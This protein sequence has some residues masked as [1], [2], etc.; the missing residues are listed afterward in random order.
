VIFKKIMIGIF[1]CITLHGCNSKDNSLQ[2]CKELS[3]YVNSQLPELNK[4]IATIYGT[5]NVSIT[6]SYCDYNSYNDSRFNYTY[7]VLEESSNSI[8]NLRNNF[9]SN[10]QVQNLFDYVK[11]VRF[12]Y[13][14][15]RNQN[16]V[17]EVE[18]FKNTCKDY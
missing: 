12:H 15:K 2:K 9:C 6:G 14:L 4:E 7:D 11:E 10:S 8:K 5:N 17:L 3:N 1:L 18:F 13:Y 16:K